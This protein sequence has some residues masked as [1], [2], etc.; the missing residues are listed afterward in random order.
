MGSRSS[1]PPI[2]RGEPAQFAIDA[3][4]AHPAP[5]KSIMSNIILT[6]CEN[7]LW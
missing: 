6:F 5:I 7:G 4:N 3:D 2:T 1:Y